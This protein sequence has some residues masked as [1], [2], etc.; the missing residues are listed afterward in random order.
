[1]SKLKTA[2]N[3]QEALFGTTQQRCVQITE[4]LRFPPALLWE[5]ISDFPHI[6]RWTQLKVK[7]IDGL[8]IGCKRTLEMASGAIV[9]ERLLSCDPA[10]MVLS[11]EIVEPNP[12]PMKNYFSTMKV[13]AMTSAHSRLHWSGH[14]TPAV[15][16]DPAK[17]DNLLRKVYIG[18]VELLIEYFA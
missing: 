10:L 13:E 14:Y 2:A 9:T 7:S 1:M 12:Y 5:I 17:T 6:D 8:G 15:G 11:Y 4:E 3:A 16:T 18:G